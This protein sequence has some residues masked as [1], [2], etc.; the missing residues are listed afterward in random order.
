MPALAVVRDL[1]EHW[2]F[3]SAEELERFETDVLSGFVETLS[4]DGTIHGTSATWI[5]PHVGSCDLAGGPRAVRRGGTNRVCYRRAMML[6]ASVDGSR[7]LVMAHLAGR[8]GHRPSYDPRFQLV[9]QRCL[10]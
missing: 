3:A 4:A 6:L 5:N 7:V 10:F 2:M 8:P 1:R 9:L